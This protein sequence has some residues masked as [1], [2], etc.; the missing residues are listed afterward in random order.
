M[1]LS[2]SRWFDYGL[3]LILGLILGLSAT[4]FLWGD[5]STRQQF[6]LGVLGNVI[7]TFLVLPG[8][9]LLNF[10]ETRCSQI[11]KFFGIRS[12]SRFFIFVGH[13]SYPN[14]SAGVA[15]VVELN[16]AHELRSSHQKF[17][18]GLGDAYLLRRLRLADVEI[19][20]I[21]ADNASD[22]SQYRE[23]SFITIGSGGSNGVS[24]M[25][26]QQL[27]ARVDFAAQ[28]IKIGNNRHENSA[29]R[30]LI[31]CRRDNSGNVWFYAA[32]QT[33]LDT[34]ATARFLRENWNLVSQ[35]YPRTDFYY[36]LETSHSASGFLPTVIEDSALR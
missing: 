13:L 24:K 15:D 9:W 33:G 31:V 10:L 29:G 6:Y 3:V 30:G 27:Q 28:K 34:T 1:H 26:E 21:V 16:E 35:K 18:P 19:E 7:A 23:S 8:F 2:S 5:A 11:R 4:P 17:V 20:V 32:G 36:L 22:Y 14:L 12:N 25:I